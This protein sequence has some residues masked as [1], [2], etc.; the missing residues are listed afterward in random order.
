VYPKILD[1][2]DGAFIIHR[3][4]RG[5]QGDFKPPYNLELCDEVTRL[6][7]TGAPGIPWGY[8]PSVFSRDMLCNDF[9]KNLKVYEWYPDKEVLRLA[10]EAFALICGRYMRGNIQ[11]FEQ[12]LPRI[13]KSRSPGYPFNL[14]YKT[15]GDV[16]ACEYGYGFVVQMISQILS[17]GKCRGEFVVRPGYVVVYCHAY[18]QTSGKGEM[19]TVDKLLHPD[20]AKRKTRTFMAGDFVCHCCA[21]MLYGDQNDELL[22]MSHEKEW[23]AVGMSPWYG[24]W[25]RM[26]RELLG[27]ESPDEAKFACED[28]SHM[29]ASVNDYFQ[30]VIYRVRN[31]NLVNEFLKPEEVSNLMTWVF[32]NSVYSYCLDVLGYLL[33]LIGKNKSGHFNTLTDNSL[34]L[35]LVNLYR[36]VYD[37]KHRLFIQMP[38]GGCA[39]AL[40]PHLPVLQEVLM[41]YFNTSA[42]IMGDD[43]IILNYDWVERTRSV[44]RHLG[45]EIK[46]ECP[47]GLLSE[48]SFLN[49]GFHRTGLV[50]YMRP[51]FDKL[52]ASILFNWKSRSW[53]LTYV[54]VCA[55]RMLVFPFERYRVEADAM[56]NYITQH[57]EDDMRRETSMDSKITYASA[58]ASRMS[59]RDNRWL[60]SGLEGVHNGEYRKMSGTAVSFLLDS[61]EVE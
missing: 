22:R 60:V 46:L 43:S 2:Y 7:K 32:E 18:W 35:I 29:E 52:R 28:V 5:I 41:C 24:G 23:S 34:C 30:T 37:M 48:S 16:L 47:V 19:R 10:E 39:H 42:R 27:K 13:D 57:H 17:T 11:T 26:A 1:A 6:E 8:G 53:R 33:L 3:Q 25:D 56:L 40:P 38:H 14:R 4:T 54:K 45:F 49:A 15:K 59:D 20:V 9:E 31:E 44:V 55:Y 36:M 21:L 58:L 50:W 51:N 12:I 61:L